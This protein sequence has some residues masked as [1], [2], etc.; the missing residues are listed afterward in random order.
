MCLMVR[1]DFWSGIYLISHAWFISEG[2]IKS[3]APFRIRPEQCCFVLSAQAVSIEVSGRLDVRSNRSMEGWMRRGRGEGWSPSFSPPPS[4]LPAWNFSAASLGF[5][6][7]SK[8]SAQTSERS[9]VITGK[10]SGIN[11]KQLC[12]LLLWSLGSLLICTGYQ[13]SLSPHLPA[14]SSPLI[15]LAL[16]MVSGSFWSSCLQT[17]HVIM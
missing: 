11:E 5:L 13:V 15:S 8:T 1:C 7:P 10:E 6:S 2:D 17:W 3:E 12:D 14:F 9:R 16:Q 4:L